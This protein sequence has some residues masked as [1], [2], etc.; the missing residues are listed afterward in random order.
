MSDPLNYDIDWP[1][2]LPTKRFSPIH[3]FTHPYPNKYWVG[4]RG[5]AAHFVYD[6]GCM[7]LL[8]TKLV[9]ATSRGGNN[10]KNM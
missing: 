4:R 5:S 10:A 1:A 7:A 9:L 2:F 8:S 6:L 3:A